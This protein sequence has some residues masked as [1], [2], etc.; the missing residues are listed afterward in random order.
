MPV[1]V[2]FY[3]TFWCVAR[4]DQA[5]FIKHVG[6]KW[7]IWPEESITHAGYMRFYVWSIEQK[8]KNAHLIDFDFSTD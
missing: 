7:Q 2:L 3:A 8:E 5:H 6:Y 1:L 4:W